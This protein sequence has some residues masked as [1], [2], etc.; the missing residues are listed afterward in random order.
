MELLSHEYCRTRRGWTYCPAR[1]RPSWIIRGACPLH[2]LNEVG[3]RGKRKEKQEEHRSAT[4]TLRGAIDLARPVKRRATDTFASAT[5]TFF[6]R[7]FSP[8]ECS[9]LLSAELSLTQRSWTI[10]PARAHPSWIRRGACPLHD[11]EEVRKWERKK[12][13]VKKTEKKSS[14]HKCDYD[15]DCNSLPSVETGATEE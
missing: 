13:K 10:C 4:D 7:L 8:S 3:T 11:L 2:D 1:A 12:V 6:V 14:A 15:C 5:D 9:E